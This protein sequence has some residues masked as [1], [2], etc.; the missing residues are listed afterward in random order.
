MER[1]LTLAR[2]LASAPLEI[3]KHPEWTGFHL[4][5]DALDSALAPALYT[6]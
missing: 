6:L 3:A 1:T 5:L 2:Q 4:L